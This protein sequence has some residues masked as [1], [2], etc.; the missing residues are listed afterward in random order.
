[1]PRAL[2]AA[3]L[4]RVDPGVLGILPLHAEACVLSENE[5]ISV[6]WGLEKS[7]DDLFREMQGEECLIIRH[8]LPQRQLR[9]LAPSAEVSDA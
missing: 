3:A 4:G 7:L 5:I 1:M 2:R 8:H 9:A 6:I